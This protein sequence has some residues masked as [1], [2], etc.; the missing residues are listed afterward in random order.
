MEHQAETHTPSALVG[1]HSNAFTITSGWTV[2]IEHRFPT[3]PAIDLVPKLD[4]LQMVE[5]DV[6]TVCD[7]SWQR[8]GDMNANIP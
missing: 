6:S 4:R 1:G 2:E 8:D 3:K 5:V 7:Q